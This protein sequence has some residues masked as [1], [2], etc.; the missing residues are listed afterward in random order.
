MNFTKTITLIAAAGALALPAVASADTLTHP[1][2]GAQNL[3]SG[4]GYL[5][6]SQPA[7]DSGYQL[8]VRASD[9]TV[10][11]PAVG[12]FSAPVQPAIGSNQTGIDGRRLE[13]LYS[14]GGDIFAYDLK[15]KTESKVKGASNP[16]VT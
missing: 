15:A 7:A 12:K 11:V 10:S 1:V 5:A 4:G 6:W 3:A 2:T 9:G 16:G 14:R 13:V 8:A